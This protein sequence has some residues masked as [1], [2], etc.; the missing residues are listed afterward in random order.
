MLR[1]I[2]S[3]RRDRLGSVPILVD[4][5]MDVICSAAG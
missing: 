1:Y 2:I 4:D 5:D 3:Q